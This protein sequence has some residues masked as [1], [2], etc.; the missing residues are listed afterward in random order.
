MLNLLNTENYFV[1]FITRHIEQKAMREKGNVK[2]NVELNHL[3]HSREEL[4]ILF[5]SEGV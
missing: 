5:L 3:F 2:L 1:L 4:M